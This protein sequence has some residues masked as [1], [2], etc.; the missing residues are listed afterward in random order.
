MAWELVQIVLKGTLL[1]LVA[2]ACSAGCS[3]TVVLGSECPGRRG[4]CDLDIPQGEDSG[5]LGT[6]NEELDA[7]A[8]DGN[9]LPIEISQSDANGFPLGAADAY[10]APS[11]GAPPDAGQPDAGLLQNPSFEL[12]ENPAFGSLESQFGADVLV[13]DLGGFVPLAGGLFANI[14]PWFACW[15]GAQVESDLAGKAGGLVATEGQ[16]L[17]TTDYGPFIFLPGLFQI[18]RQP[19]QAGRTYS[20]RVDVLN[21]GAGR[22]ALQVGATNLACT[23]PEAYA[24]TPELL[25]TNRW[26]RHCLTFRPTRALETFTLVPVSVGDAE[27]EAEGQ[28]SFD[29][30]QE[31]ATCP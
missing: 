11:D 28:V 10:I 29:N 23:P 17:I 9:G 21:S 25:N 14:D 7:G 30:L 15:L 20:F 6:D 2:G 26:E 24:T 13:N 1:G 3:K 16:A 12:L 22:A 31:V 19:L 8:R 27:A 18:L 4:P 5:L